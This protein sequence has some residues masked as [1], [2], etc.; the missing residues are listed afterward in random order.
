M[1]QIRKIIKDLDRGVEPRKNLPIYANYLADTYL[2]YASIELLFSAYMLVETCQEGIDLS[3]EEERRYDEICE[4][5]PHIYEEDPLM[6]E[7]CIE[8][9]DKIRGEI[10][11]I[12]E[13]YTSYTDQ[14]ICYDYVF[15]HRKYD[16]KE[17]EAFAKDVF[18]T[19]EDVF[20]KEL[21]A[22]LVGNKDQ[23]IVK[24]RLQQLMGMIP[25]HMTNQRLMGKIQDTGSLYI[26][27]DMA[28]LDNFIYMIRS[29]AMLQKAP[30]EAKDSIADLLKE[31][32]NTDFINLTEES[33]DAM[34]KELEKAGEYI[35]H[36]TDF[37]YQLQKVVNAMYA[38]CLASCHK[39]EESDLYLHCRDVLMEVAKGSLSEDSLVKLEGKI[40]TYVEKSSYLEAVLFEIKHSHKKIIDELGKG[41]EFDAFA[42]IANLLSDSLFI[43]ME[44]F[45]ENDTV[46]AA[47][48]AK[49]ISELTAEL[50]EFLSTLSKPLKKAVMAEVLEKLPVD[51]RTAGEIETYIR[52]NLYGCQN[53]AEKKAA[54]I[55][56]REWMDEAA[57]WRNP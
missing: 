44:H 19:E 47:A 15:K 21:M 2:N 45:D 54:M 10:T 12:M 33:F 17:E 22:F 31:L 3:D 39:R 40:E 52:T 48:E 57:E 26:G 38:L 27:G 11:D 43:D 55:E 18:E 7:A 4:E 36:V 42:K 35:L 41:E 49:K 50:S 24:E 34:S 23:S 13:K 56:L 1:N 37:Y 51:F 30:G 8:R 46:N 16:F 32:Q 5:I 29:A 6:R 28:S 25:V 53:Q 9:L 20:V 14:L